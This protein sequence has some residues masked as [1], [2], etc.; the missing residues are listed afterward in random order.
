[1][2]AGVKAGAC[3]LMAVAPFGVFGCQEPTQIELLIRTDLPCESL[4][5]VAITVG[6]SKFSEDRAP[7][8]S[9][10]ACDPETGFVGTLV[11]TPSG[12]E[13]AELSVR[14][15]AAVNAAS[16]EDCQPSESVAESY[17][18]CIV[19]RRTMRYLPNDRLDVAVDLA[20]KCQGTPCGP[21]TTCYRAGLCGNDR[22][23]S[24]EACN[25]SGS[26]EPPPGDDPEGAPPLE[27]ST[28]SAPSFATGDAFACALDEA[29][30]LRCWGRGREG[31]T[32][33]GAVDHPSPVPLGAD[34]TW[35]LVSAGTSYA[36]AVA[37]DDS[38]WCWGSNAEGQFGNGSQTGGASPAA[39]APGL[40]VASLATGFAHTC[41]TTPA[42]ELYCWG[43]NNTSQ[44][45]PEDDGTDR[46]FLTPERVGP[47]S[48]WLS[49]SAGA[50]HTCAVREGGELYCWGSNAFSEIGE[51]ESEDD[52]PEQYDGFGVDLSV[53]L[54][55]PS[56]RPW[57]GVSC[58][59]FHTCGLDDTGEL[60]CWGDNHSG[61]LGVEQS[62]AGPFGFLESSS[63]APVEG[64][65]GP[66]RDVSAGGAHTCAVR[67]TGE[68]FC[69]GDNTF[70]QLGTGDIEPS[71]TPVLVD[72]GSHGAWVAVRSGGAFTCARK[73][74]GE[75]WCWG[76]NAS[77]EAGKGAVS[78]RQTSPAPVSGL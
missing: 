58:G 30:A 44:V 22:V 15:V 75:L 4:H 36:C 39:V 76:Q 63:P 78:L 35:K 55:T 18:G 34:R 24:S 69:W 6:P 74:N 19:A 61:Q 77:G 33:D 29:G 53:P 64:T 9:T 40:S 57:K 38:L 65:P 8:A 17:R 31:Q 46:R 7:S 26:C 56:G 52:S 12:D 37:N 67:S 3:A 2:R 71:S 10:L 48:G 62:S 20:A 45:G 70:G 27:P 28:T 47:P 32:G 60:A 16:V 1:M 14:V 11:I 25:A 5:G 50:G 68:L 54:V 21:G 72:D 66:W 41:V 59:S 13:G 42:G 51:R 49:V 43:L 23:G 73:G